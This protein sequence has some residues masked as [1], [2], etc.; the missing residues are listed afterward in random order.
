MNHSNW[1]DEI[2]ADAKKWPRAFR[3]RLNNGRWTLLGANDSVQ[4]E[5]RACGER[6][7]RELRLPQGDVDPVDSLLYR[8]KEKA[9]HT[10]FSQALKTHRI[11]SSKVVSN[12]LRAS[13]YPLRGAL[14]KFVREEQG[15][16]L[17]AKSMLRAQAGR[18]GQAAAARKNQERKAREGI[19]RALQRLGAAYTNWPDLVREFYTNTS[20]TAYRQPISPPAF[21]PPVFDRLNQSPTDWIKSATAAWEEHRDRFLRGCDFWATVGVDD[22]IP[23]GKP[24]R[25]GGTCG[26]N[27]KRG[28]NTAIDQRNEWAAK[29]LVRV[30]LKE[31]AAQDCADPS[32]VGRI[33]R[34]IL[35]QA[36]WQEPAKAKTSGTPNCITH[37][38]YSK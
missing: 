14:I 9:H 5:F 13:T 2:I 8:I 19:V 26:P 23:V 24:T 7:H 12:G 21:Q 17:N 11:G 22:E 33:A 35:R 30:P 6:I 36:N 20:E 34:G 3:A 31:I 27:G 1:R 32:T 4:Q 10:R 37:Q 28:Y 38:K 15:T 18:S 29:Y 16:V 25:G